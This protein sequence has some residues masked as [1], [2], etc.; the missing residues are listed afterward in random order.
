MIEWQQV[1]TAG[2]LLRFLR[3]V[4][5]D[6]WNALATDRCNQNNL[7]ILSTYILILKSIFSYSR[8]EII[9]L[10]LLNKKNIKLYKYPLSFVQWTV[11]GVQIGVI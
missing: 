8:K 1:F 3:H 4:I 11:K 9:Y 7:E 6:L 5:H 2:N 10:G